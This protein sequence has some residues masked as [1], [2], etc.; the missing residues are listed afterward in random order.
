MSYESIFSSKENYCNL[1]KSFVGRN[2]SQKKEKFVS[3]DL[4]IQGVP[5]MRG[6][7]LTMSY[8]L[9]VELGKNI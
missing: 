8:W 4:F 1:K 6:K 3:I 5:E 7:I 9:H 2:F